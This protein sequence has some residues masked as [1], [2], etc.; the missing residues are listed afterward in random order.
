MPFVERRDNTNNTIAGVNQQIST[1]PIPFFLL[2]LCSSPSFSPRCPPGTVPLRLRQFYLT[3]FLAHH[4]SQVFH[5]V[6]HHT[7]K[8]TKIPLHP[9]SHLFI[10]LHTSP[11]PKNTHR[12][13]GKRPLSTG[14]HG[15]VC[16]VENKAAWRI[17]C[18]ELTGYTNAP[19]FGVI[20]RAHEHSSETQ[21]VKERTL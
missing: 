17:I 14:S 20:F 18:R 4:R 11:D 10:P 3:P 21:P 5:P 2:R 13:H 12:P 8:H 19:K 7:S 16:K 9:S 1:P 6:S 15:I